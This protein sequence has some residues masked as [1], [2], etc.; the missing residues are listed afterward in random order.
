MA[1]ASGPEGSN[2]V[3][4]VDSWKANEER[5]LLWP[6][7]DALRPDGGPTTRWVQDAKV[8]HVIR[9]VQLITGLK[10]GPVGDHDWLLAKAWSQCRQEL[11]RQGGPL[12]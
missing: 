6:V 1:V 9:W 2:T 11:V 10:L 3:L 7:P 5:I 4:V 12:E 8:E